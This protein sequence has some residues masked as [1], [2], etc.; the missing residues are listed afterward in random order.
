MIELK[1]KGSV[2]TCYDIKDYI[3]AAV[4]ALKNI[5]PGSKDNHNEIFQQMAGN[6]EQ[7]QAFKGA[8]RTGCK[9][10]PLAKFIS[11]VAKL[12]QRRSRQVSNLSYQ[13]R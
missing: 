4:A 11:I 6:V 7:V 13:G 2:C 10:Y 5:E 3:K 12:A 8:K 1:E 9:V